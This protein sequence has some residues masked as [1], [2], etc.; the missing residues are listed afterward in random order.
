MANVS[1]RLDDSIL[2]RLAKLSAKTGRSKTFYMTEA[3][4]QHIEDLEDIYD[5]EQ[6]LIKIR[7]GKS[8]T[9]TLSQVGEELGLAS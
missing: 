1:L 9:Y 3:I 2:Q 5:A 7:S 8:R 4:S 6:E